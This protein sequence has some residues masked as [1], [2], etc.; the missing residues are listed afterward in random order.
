M[1]WG[2]AGGI[3]VTKP[4]TSPLQVDLQSAQGEQS[5]QP[6][7]N[8]F[9]ANLLGFLR[10]VQLGKVTRS[11]PF[12]IRVDD[13]VGALPVRRAWNRFLPRCGTTTMAPGECPIA[14]RR[15]TGSRRTR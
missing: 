4:C 7:G 6:L 13:K 8:R 2:R 12:D 15:G 9:Q 10:A 5:P 1:R 14:R 3:A 11:Q